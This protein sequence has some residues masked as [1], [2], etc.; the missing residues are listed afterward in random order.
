M[1]VAFVAGAT[2][3]TGRVVVEALRRRSIETHAHVRPD[4]PKLSDWRDRWGSQG[5]QVDT[6]PWEPDA[7]LAR[8]RELRP[9]LVFALLGTTRKRA[10]R[11]G[12]DAAEAYERIDYGLT[13]M[14]LT[15]A[16]GCGHEPRFVYLSS[17]GLSPNTTNAYAR[18][19]VRVEAEL[20]ET[21][22]PHL[23]ARP[24]FIVGDRDEPRTGERWA[25][26]VAD[27]ALSV[28]GALGAKRAAARYASTTNETLGE[29]LVRIAVDAGTPARH[30]AESEM[31]RDGP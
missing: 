20:S 2:G 27:G 16:A 18:A 6:T 11:E 15:A 7:L 9:T 4:S 26:R 5:V 10:G 25:A 30:I 28:I 21:S 13:S 14:L 19:R 3:H 24:S 1:A 8:L 12:M 17:A 29:A 22:L 31:L 23:I